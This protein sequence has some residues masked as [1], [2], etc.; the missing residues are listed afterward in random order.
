MK[1][2]AERMGVSESYISRVR[3]GQRGIGRP[4]IVGARRAWPDM[5]LDWLFPRDTEAPTAQTA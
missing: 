5:P 4:F 3:S 2:L 1:E